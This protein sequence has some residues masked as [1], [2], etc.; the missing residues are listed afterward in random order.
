MDQLPMRNRDKP[1]LH[2]LK[3]LYHSVNWQMVQA[4]DTALKDCFHYTV[5]DDILYK[6]KES[7][8][9]LSIV[10]PEHLVSRFFKKSHDL[11]LCTH[12]GIEKMSCHMRSVSFS[13][14]RR[15]IRIIVTRVIL[16]CFPK[17][18]LIGTTFFTLG[19]QPIF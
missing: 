13:G 3:T 19:S 16:V 17:E 5:K 7:S 15:R 10:I 14:M 8:G 9:K 6:N 4:K 1:A 18:C 12:G 2:E 11:N